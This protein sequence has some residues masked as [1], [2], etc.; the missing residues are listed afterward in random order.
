M[1]LISHPSL[2]RLRGDP[3]RSSSQS[4]PHPCYETVIR[5]Q[6]TLK[7]ALTMLCEM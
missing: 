5:S 4:R 1:S 2:T 3:R 6:K 7:D